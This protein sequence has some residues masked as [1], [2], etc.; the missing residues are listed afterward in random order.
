MRLI[1]TSCHNLLKEK[2]TKRFY[3]TT[4]S[5]NLKSKTDKYESKRKQISN[6]NSV[7]ERVGD[8]EFA[9][10]QGLSSEQ[11]ACKDETVNERNVTDSGISLFEV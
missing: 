8:F 11:C 5:Q 7:R 3:A 4:A 2:E 1:Q 6:C 9:Q 10:N